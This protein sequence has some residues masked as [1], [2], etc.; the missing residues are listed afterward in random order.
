MLGC[1]SF[2]DTAD[3]ISQWTRTQAGDQM[4][5]RIIRVGAIALAAGLLLASPTAYAF[6]KASLSG[7][8]VCT[9]EDIG[10]QG[11]IPGADFFATWLVNFNGAGSATAKISIAVI[12]DEVCSGT[13][14]GSY[15]VK[16]DGTGSGTLNW[17]ITDDLLSDVGLTGICA[18]S[19]ESQLRLYL[20]HNDFGI[21]I[22]KGVL[23]EGV[24]SSGT[25]IAQIA[26]RFTCQPQ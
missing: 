3:N 14:T 18:P 20:V 17:T 23:W 24:P 4:I 5:W 6:S 19:F 21:L 8:Y 15:T 11:A 22:I 2:S 1:G 13:G 10:V 9:E 7:R 26:K 16:S 25:F 12:D